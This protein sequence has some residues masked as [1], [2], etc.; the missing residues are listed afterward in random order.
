MASMKNSGVSIIM[1]TSRITLV[2]D[3][4]TAPGKSIM[5]SMC[6]RTTG[7]MHMIILIPSRIMM[8]VV[9]GV[10][11]FVTSSNNSGFLI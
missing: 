1:F 11:C 10:L 4:S 7:V 6:T 5:A 2:A 9:T 3:T 8:T